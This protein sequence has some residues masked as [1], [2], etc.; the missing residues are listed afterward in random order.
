MALVGRGC[1]GVLDAVR[2]YFSVT[3]T[4]FNGSAFAVE[5]MPGAIWCPNARM[6]LT[7]NMLRH[8]LRPQ[9]ADTVAIRSI[10]EDDRVR[11]LTWRQLHSQVA[12]LA[13]TLSALGVQPG[14]R[15][16]AV[17]SNIPEAIIGLWATASL[18]ATWT[19]NSPELSVTAKLDRLVSW[20]R[21]C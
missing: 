12:A 5:R 8:A 17:L 9:C 6:N 19:I 4:G 7:E 15:V 20:S 14:E 3:G 10:T 11:S 2:E 18:G 13:R 16:A 21:W 1:V